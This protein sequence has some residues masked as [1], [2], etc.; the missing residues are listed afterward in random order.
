MS[1]LRTFNE[2]SQSA[3]FVYGN[4]YTE[5]TQIVQDMGA[6]AVENVGLY[7]ISSIRGRRECTF[8]K[9]VTYLRYDFG[10]LRFA[11]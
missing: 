10:R 2:I 11:W 4:I 8:F 6:V 1:F 5:I 7:R 9:S 3:V